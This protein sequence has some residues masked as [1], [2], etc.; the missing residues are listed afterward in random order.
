MPQQ[1]TAPAAH[2]HHCE[3]TRVLHKIKNTSSSLQLQFINWSSSHEQSS[4]AIFA[5][6]RKPKISSDS[7][8]SKLPIP[9]TFLPAPMILF[10]CSTWLALHLSLSTWEPPKN[11]LFLLPKK[12]C[13]YARQ[14]LSLT[15]KFFFRNS[16]LCKCQ[17]W[18][19]RFCVFP[20]QRGIFRLWS[21]WGKKSR[22]GERI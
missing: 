17:S 10:P 3:H 12:H 11:L 16:K 15:P 13:S 14:F 5:P 7:L 21:F 6:G 1:V 8:S 20:S 2:A 18:F 9:F 4:M 22:K 19:P